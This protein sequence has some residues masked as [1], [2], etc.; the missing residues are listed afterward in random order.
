[1]HDA[2]GLCHKVLPTALVATV[3]RPHM[4]RAELVDRIDRLVTILA[5]Q[6]AN[7]SVTSG[8]QAADEGVELLSERAVLVEER[9]HLRVRDRIVLRYYART[10]QHLMDRPRKA[11]H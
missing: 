1:V 9:H 5:A 3:V 10:I 8:R 4:T 11:A 6:G 2:I 7:L